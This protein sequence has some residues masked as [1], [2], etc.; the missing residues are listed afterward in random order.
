VYIRK[1]N[2][3]MKNNRKESFGREILLTM[4]IAIFEDVTSEVW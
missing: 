3:S 2:N 4:K 1:E